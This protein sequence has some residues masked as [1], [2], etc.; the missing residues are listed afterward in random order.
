MS[1]VK[2]LKAKFQIDESGSKTPVLE[3]QNSTIEERKK[4]FGHTD[5]NIVIEKEEKVIVF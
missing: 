5:K 3:K 2:E 1:T 4:F